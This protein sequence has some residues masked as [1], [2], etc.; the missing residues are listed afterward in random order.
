[1]KEKKAWAQ[2]TAK[3]KEENTRRRELCPTGHDERL[4]V[5]TTK[6]ER[7]GERVKEEG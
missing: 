7:V 4:D 2:R 5:I 6:K 1:M 3:Q